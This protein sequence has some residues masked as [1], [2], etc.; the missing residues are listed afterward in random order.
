MSCLPVKTEVGGGQLL[1]AWWDLT[2]G[3]IIPPDGSIRSQF[4]EESKHAVSILICAVG[5]TV[6]LS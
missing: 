1:R 4:M 6:S 5:T 2:G 3:W